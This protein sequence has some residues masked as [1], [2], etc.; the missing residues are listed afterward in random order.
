MAC[1]SQ[2]S[3]FSDRVQGGQLHLPPRTVGPLYA[4]YE[5]RRRHT[6]F[7]PTTTTPTGTRAC[8]AAWT[9]PTPFPGH[10]GRIRRA[11]DDLLLAGDLSW[12]DSDNSDEATS[13]ETP[14]RLMAWS[15]KDLLEILCTEMGKERKYT[16]LTKQKIIENLFKIVSEKKSRKHVEDTF[17]TPH[18]STG[19]PQTP[20]KRQRKNDHPLRL[21]T[22]ENIFKGKDEVQRIRTKLDG[23]YCCTY[24]GKMNSLVGCWRK[25]LMVA[26]DARRV[27]VLCHRV[28]LSHKILC[29]THKYQKVHKIVEEALKK[30]ESEVGPLD[31]GN[32]QP[33]MGRG[34]VN[35]LSVGAEVQRLCAQ[36]I[37][38]LD[39]MSSSLTSSAHLQKA[40][41]DP[42]EELL[43]CAIWHR[44][45]D[46]AGYLAEP[47]GTLYKPNRRFLITEL[48]PSTEYVFKIVAFSERRELE[49]WEVG[50]TTCELL[51]EDVI[52][53]PVAEETMA[54]TNRIGLSNPSPEGIEPQKS[55]DQIY[56]CKEINEETEGLSESALDEEPNST[57]NT[58]SNQDSNSTEQNQPIDA[59]KLDNVL[60]MVAVPLVPV[61]V[62]RPVAEPAN[63]SLVYHLR[64][65]CP[66]QRESGSSLQRRCEKYEELG[67]KDGLLEGGDYEYCVKVIRWLECKGLIESNFRV[68]FLT[69]FS[70]RANS[71]EKRILSAYVDTL[72]DDPRSLA[73]Q[74]VDTF[75]DAI[76]SKRS[77]LL[78]TGS[79]YEHQKRDYGFTPAKL[80]VLIRARH[81]HEFATSHSPAF[82]NPFI[83]ETRLIRF[84]SPHTTDAEEKRPFVFLPPPI[85]VQDPS[86]FPAS[87]KLFLHCYVSLPWRPLGFVSILDAVFLPFVR[88]FRGLTSIETV[89]FTSHPSAEV[90][91]FITKMKQLYLRSRSIK[92]LFSSLSA[93]RSTEYNS[94]KG[95]KSD[96]GSVEP[97]VKRAQMPSWR[98]FSYEEINKATRGFHQDNLVGRGG[99][100][101]VYRGELED[102]QIIAVKR[103]T[104]AA[105]DEHKEKEFLT[106]L[107]TVGHVR[108]PN[109]TA[110]LG[111][112]IDKDL[113][114]V[115]ECK[116]T[117]NSLDASLHEIIV[118]TARGLHYLHKECQR[119]IIH[120]D[121]KASNIL[122]SACF[123]P[124]I[125]DFGLA[126]WLPS[127]WTHRAVA[128]IEGTFGCLAP[129]YFTR[130]IVDEKTD[131]FAFGVLILEVISGRKPVDGSHKSLLSWAKPYLNDVKIEMLVDAR[132]EDYDFD[133]LKR[134]TFIASLCIRASPSWRPSMLEV[135]DLI[136][137]SHVSPE[138][139]EMPE[140]EV[141]EEDELW[142]FDDL[143]ECDTPTSSASTIC[144]KEAV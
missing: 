124:Q 119:R 138:K 122:L 39:I 102:G 69:W 139:W 94:C 73:G 129:E 114:L 45:V 21:P 63:S 10:A 125:S 15:R 120:R 137:G 56:S 104:S 16:G 130:G 3:A 24:C 46:G 75:S 31:G 38:V 103:L 113:Y 8:A 74:V 12:K 87:G 115:F 131:V 34:I 111:C 41:L 7:S 57:L 109:V 99:Y 28:F 29:G 133:Q 68:K 143:D 97:G 95:T 136:E 132:L 54:K 47:T 134:L 36:A 50:V 112:C 71:Q 2:D 37:E 126:K 85:R 117:T 141:E 52:T 26:K 61:P 123:Q 76:F 70:L 91:L 65:P 62:C 101:E 72:I 49:N 78:P 51:S 88:L 77:P 22:T 58:D 30:L 20:T 128:P 116:F 48:F 81:S 14:Y 144:S 92:R 86:S 60:E 107:G 18:S 9:S 108:H 4:G 40:N 66:N 82:I 79:K 32:G 33:N 105:S 142:S 55:S 53:N 17:S 23:S 25:Q 35:R 106:E 64:I 1:L 13:A 96:S 44:K 11:P 84:A 42:S 90:T 121:I 6:A 43:G 118:G 140:V 80:T 127:E 98:C 19:E 5:P 67:M 100:A 89:P 83:K 27:D 93:R 135:L 59:P 110:L